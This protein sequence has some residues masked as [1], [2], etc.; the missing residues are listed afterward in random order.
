VT[1]TFRLRD[2]LRP[3]SLVIKVGFEA[4]SCA[5]GRYEPLSGVRGGV[6]RQGRSEAEEPPQAA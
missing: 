6:T 1:L 4:E 2:A 3:A 5:F